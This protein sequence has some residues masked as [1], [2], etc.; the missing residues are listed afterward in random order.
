[1]LEGLRSVPGGDSILPFVLQFYGNPSSYL[2]EDDFGET[3]EIR[4]GEGGEQGDAMMPMLHALGQHQAL[5]S[6]QSKLQ[7]HERL[8]AFLDD[9]YVV[10]KPDRIREIH[11][12]LRRDLWQFS[13]IRINEGK[14]QNLEPWRFCPTRFGPV[15]GRGQIK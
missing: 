4:Q 11:G 14:T 9:I 7:E 2:W 10:S 12:F 15:A 3:H 6:V 13:R 1:M 5:L 8:L